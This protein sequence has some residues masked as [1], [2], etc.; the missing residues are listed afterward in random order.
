MK[1]PHL[2]WWI[3]GLLAV[4]TGLSYMDRQ[5]LP[6]VIGEIQKS[7]PISEQEYGNLSF[8]FLVAYAIM[9]AGGGKLMD[10]LGTRWG[11]VLTLTWWSLA[12]A[13]QGT[14]NSV[15]G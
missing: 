11:Y 5:T 1:I 15:F 4:A 6:V 14:V 9:Y 2:R 3:V 7:I 10:M 12:T 8:L 13:M